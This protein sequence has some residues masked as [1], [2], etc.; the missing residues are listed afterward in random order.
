MDMVDG[1]LSGGFQGAVKINFGYNP[2]V[3]SFR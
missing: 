2:N 3:A 1:D